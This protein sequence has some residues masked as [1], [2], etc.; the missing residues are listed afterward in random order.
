ML[1]SEQF[2]YAD[3]IEVESDTQI[4]V[5]VATLTKTGGSLNLTLLDDLN[6]PVI[7]APVQIDVFTKEGHPVKRDTVMTD[8]NGQAVY[9]LGL[10]PDAY[11]AKVEFSGHS[12]WRSSNKT[13]EFEIIRCQPKSSIQPSESLFQPIS[14]PLSLSIHR[15]DCLQFDADYM[16]SIGSA[17][18]RIHLDEGQNN[19][20]FQ[21]SPKLSNPETLTLEVSIIEGNLFEHEILHRDVVFYDSISEAHPQLKQNWQHT[22]I[23]LQL[24]PYLQQFPIALKHDDIAIETITDEHGIARFILPQTASGCI[25]TDIY[26]PDQ[27]S[28]IGRISDEICIPEK[29]SNWRIVIAGLAFMALA[30]AAFGIRKRVNFK[31]K[32]PAPNKIQSAPIESVPLPANESDTC[33]I[34]CRA[35]DFELTPSEVEIEINGETKHP[36]AWP[37]VLH[38]SGRIRIRHRA[39]LDWNGTLKPGRK[40]T[41]TLTTRR[42]Y[43][44]SCFNQAT[45]ETM[46][47]GRET[48][49]LFLEL[50][51][52]QY[53]DKPTQD[54]ATRFCDLISEAAF[55]DKILS[56]DELTEL[57]KLS[58]EFSRHSRQTSFKKTK[59]AAN[60]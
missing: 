16:V 29:A 53:P 38:N 12:P 15:S 32:L 44:I 59:K 31:P 39:C 7:D 28:E 50:L 20:S 9:P 36:N 8:P 42:D 58:M 41:I 14:K 13:V 21:L 19:A 22:W 2:A 60:P 6:H 23:E 4:I 46:H 43:A 30:I 37:F 51:I 40:H 18:S 33:S 3:T 52:K 48:P 47:W 57:H 10:S 55:N 27:F 54:K 45:P 11:T 49:A 34:V 26:R 24:H 5:Q 56:D 25:E 17:S 1:I 35:S